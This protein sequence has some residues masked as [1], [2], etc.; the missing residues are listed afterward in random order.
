MSV[1]LDESKVEKGRFAVIKKS[2][3]MREQM[4]GY[5]V[6]S[7]CYNE[8]DGIKAM[9]MG[10]VEIAP[11]QQVPEHNSAAEEIYYVLEGKG[12]IGVEG[13]DYEVSEG[14]IV[15]RA[16]D[17]WHGPHINTGTT[18]FKLLFVVSQSMKPATSAD[19]WFKGEKDLWKPKRLD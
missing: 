7:L 9:R 11:G 10:L 6:S 8:R 1:K 3:W 2:D 18:P 5:E 13:I 19:V 12:T 14:D 4:K 16:E 17:L 15:Y